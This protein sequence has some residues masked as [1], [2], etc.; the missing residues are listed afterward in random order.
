MIFL[1]AALAA[2]ISALRAAIG[3]AFSPGTDHASTS[4]CWFT[5][6]STTS[7]FWTA[8]VLMVLAM[9]LYLLTAIS[10][11]DK[12]DTAI[13]GADT[14]CDVHLCA[15]RGD[16][17]V[18]FK[19]VGTASDYGFLQAFHSTAL[20]KHLTS[21]PFSTPNSTMPGHGISRFV[22]MVHQSPRQTTR[23]Y[24]EVVRLGVDGGIPTVQ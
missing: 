10:M 8:T 13:H 18:H 5:F 4:T 22:D 17:G 16:K 3:L 9:Y 7:P 15:P 11:T 23:W 6:V 21:V 1:L 2:G 14:G 19:I 24:R 20:H 12:V